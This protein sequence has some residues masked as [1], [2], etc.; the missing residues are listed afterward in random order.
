MPT[1]S[2]CIDNIFINFE[3]INS[4]LQE[5]FLSENKA[6]SIQIKKLIKTHFKKTTS[7]CRRLFNK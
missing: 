2:T 5:P 3:P 1:S 7:Q 6:L 4:V